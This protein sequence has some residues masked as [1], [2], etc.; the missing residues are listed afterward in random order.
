MA[1][2]RTAD[3]VQWGFADIYIADADTAEPASAATLA[4]P[5]TGWTGVGFTA[6]GVTME[7]GTDTEEIRVEEQLTAVGRVLTAVNVS[8]SFDF[9]EDVIE[10]RLLAYGFG[11]LTTTAAGPTQI[12]K[13]TLV[14]GDVLEEKAI[15]IVADNGLGFKDRIYI[16][17]MMAG[18]SVSTSYKR[19]EKHVYPVEFMATCDPTQIVIVQQ[20]AVATS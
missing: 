1:P 18:G 5:V 9:A 3:Q 19:A 16:P 15:C 12:G 10:N 20:T 14:L 13:K 4:D 6:E 11:T 17:R 2:T 7:V 8:V